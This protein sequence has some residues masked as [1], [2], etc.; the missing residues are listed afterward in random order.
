LTYIIKEFSD[1]NT[2]LSFKLFIV[3]LGVRVFSI[4]EYIK[5]ENGNFVQS[6]N[7]LPIGKGKTEH[8]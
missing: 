4:I 8:L 1:N 7:I 2:F 5:Y 3:F 6:C